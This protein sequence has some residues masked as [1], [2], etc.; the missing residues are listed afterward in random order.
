MLLTMCRNSMWTG[1]GCYQLFHILLFYC[2]MLID[3]QIIALADGMY[4]NVIKIKPPMVV[5]ME[6]CKSIVKALDEVLV[7]LYHC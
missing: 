7:K 1:C 4:D 6:D 5:T 3:H 2:S